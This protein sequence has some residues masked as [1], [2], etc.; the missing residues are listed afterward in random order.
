MKEITPRMVASA[1]RCLHFWYLECHGN[2]ER[3][4][5]EEPRLGGTE[6]PEDSRRRRIVEWL[7]D[8]AELVW[9]GLDPQ[10][11]FGKTLDLMKRGC[12]WIYKGVLLR[13]GMWGQPDLLRKV[14][15]CSALGNHSYAPLIVKPDRGPMTKRDL[16]E[17]RTHALLLEAVLGRKPRRGWAYLGPGEM[18]EIDLRTPLPEFELLLSDM[19]R[20]RKGEL[21]TGG[22]RLSDCDTCAWRAHCADLWED[23]GHVCVLPGATPEVVAPLRDAGFPT[24]R[25]IAEVNPSRLVADAGI[26]PA[27]AMD[28][29]LHARARRDGAPVARRRARFVEDRPV[30]F[31]G[32]EFSGE[33][34]FLLGSLRF[35]QGQGRPKQFLVESATRRN[36]GLIWRAFLDYLARDQNAVIFPWAGSEARQLQ[37]LWDRHGGCP[38]LRK[39]LRT[40]AATLQRFVRAH[41]ALPVNAYGLAEASALFRRR[42]LS[43][44]SLREAFATW[45]E[46]RD[47]DA[48]KQVLDGHL[49]KLK[50][51]RAVY[52]GLKASQVSTGS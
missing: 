6:G 37:L 38:A 31:V 32:V 1:S 44:G 18:V 8:L 24:W 10:A 21:V 26:A 7:P 17:L 14:E 36:E 41:F 2:P 50:A 47:R 51:M 11:A 29:W 15:G 3:R 20:V 35:F 34:C 42:R 22:C 52:F 39:S 46:T 13:K 16:F 28:L 45:E 9:E 30:H 4:R 12:P 25:R 43:T 48:L 33:D 19:E 27:Q 23:S 5:P 40:R 49:E